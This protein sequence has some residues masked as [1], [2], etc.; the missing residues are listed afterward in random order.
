MSGL[1]E[2]WFLT[3]SVLIKCWQFSVVYSDNTLEPEGIEG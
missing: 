1:E 3:H 2:E